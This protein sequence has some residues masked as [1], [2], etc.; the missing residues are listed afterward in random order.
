MDASKNKGALTSTCFD[1]RRAGGV[2]KFREEKAGTGGGTW[3]Y[4]CDGVPEN[5][6][7]T[8]VSLTGIST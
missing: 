8:R 1:G 6:T 5:S 7:I 4:K 3:T 2:G